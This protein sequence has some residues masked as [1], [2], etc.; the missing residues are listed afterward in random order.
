MGIY[1]D[2]AAADDFQSHEIRGTKQQ[3]FSN[4]LMYR[5]Q[6]KDLNCQFIV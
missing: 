4:E 5:K 6:T 2:T 1:A 3:R